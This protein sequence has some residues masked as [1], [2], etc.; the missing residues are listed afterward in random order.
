MT[1]P[2][3]PDSLASVRQLLP[4]S[5]QAMAALIGDE[6]TLR[7]IAVCGGCAVRVPARTGGPAVARLVET[8]G[9]EQLA[10][11]LMHFYAGERLCVPHCAAALEA[12]RAVEIHRAAVAARQD[13][14]TMAAIVAELAHAHGLADRAVWTI[15]ARPAPLL[16]GGQ[17]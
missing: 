2:A 15:L 12:L 11:R 1:Q 6:L 13:G 17:P 10:R 9:S 3:N 14:R 16:E 8:V 4:E 7:L 5:A